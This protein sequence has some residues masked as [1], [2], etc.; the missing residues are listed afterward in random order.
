MTSRTTLCCFSASAELVLLYFTKVMAFQMAEPRARSHVADASLHH[1]A[2][3]QHVGDANAVFRRD[4]HGE[5]EHA[6]LVSEPRSHLSCPFA[7]RRLTNT[8]I[9]AAASINPRMTKPTITPTTIG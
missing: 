2:V 1:C 5:P 9:R 6:N 7:L 8:R 3:S 4:D